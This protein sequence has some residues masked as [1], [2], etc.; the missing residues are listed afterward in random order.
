MNNRP[1]ANNGF[2]GFISF[3]FEARYNYN[4]TI[5]CQVPLEFLLFVAHICANLVHFGYEQTECCYKGKQLCLN[6][7]VEIQWITW[8]MQ[9][10]MPGIPKQPVQ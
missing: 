5:C 9:T 6:C 2:C 10:S 4:E 3:W 7:R 1:L 8:R